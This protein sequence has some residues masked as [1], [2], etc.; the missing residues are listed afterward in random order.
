MQGALFCEERLIEGDGKLFQT[1]L[2][3][4]ISDELFQTFS[5]Y[6]HSFVDDDWT[7][8]VPM[9]ETYE[10]VAWA[11]LRSA[12][13]IS[14]DN[15]SQLST[16][17]MDTG[18]LDGIR[19]IFFGQS[20]KLW[21]HKLLFLD[22]VGFLS[23]GGHLMIPLTRYILIDVDDIFVGRRGTRMIA[24]DVHV[25]RFTMLIIVPHG[26]K[27]TVR[28]CPFLQAMLETM[29]K[30]R[31]IIP[32]F[33]FNLG[34]SGKYFHAGT[35]AENKGDDTLIGESADMMIYYEVSL[36]SYIA[37]RIVAG[38]DSASLFRS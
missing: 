29:A 18:K 26:E 24:D 38:V 3:L 8:F 28:V 17:I 4:I 22:A 19:R 9:H 13:N 20:L 37:T 7:V 10:T 16:I 1:L 30:W 25:G 33:R 36:G 35:E 23:N 15:S 11:N 27:L 12:S 14:V 5:T 31:K 2:L 21:L 6:G 34:F 32:G